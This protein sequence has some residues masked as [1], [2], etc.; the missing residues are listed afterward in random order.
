MSL[1]LGGFQKQTSGWIFDFFLTGGIFYPKKYQA[2]LCSVF[3]VYFVSKGKT[4]II[5]I[6]RIHPNL[7]RFLEGGLA[8]PDAHFPTQHIL[9]QHRYKGLD[10]FLPVYQITKMDGQLHLKNRVPVTLPSHPTTAE[11]TRLGLGSSS[12]KKRG[13]SIDWEKVSLFSF[14]FFFSAGVWSAWLYT[15]SI[16]TFSNTER[17]SRAIIIWCAVVPS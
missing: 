4:K 2:Y 12:S 16:S 5:W 7:S 17:V 8:S 13:E 1:C 9:D 15:R 11:P 10:C 6:R 14:F 3:L